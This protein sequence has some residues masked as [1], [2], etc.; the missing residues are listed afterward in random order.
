MKFKSTK[1]VKKWLRNL[2]VVKNDLMLKIKF[3]REISDELEKTPEF[4]ST[5]ER[6]K[7]EVENLSAKLE[8]L[9]KQTDKL[10]SYLEEHERLIMTAR[11][12]NVIRWDFIEFKVFY[13]R[14][15]AIRIHD[16]ALEKLV[17]KTVG[18][19]YEP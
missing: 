12:I 19:I 8:G 7:K 18:D 15:Q 2:P 6:Y 9:I 11:Y 5:L 13:S 17:G 3:Y 10:F 16:K 4:E 14:R 1:D